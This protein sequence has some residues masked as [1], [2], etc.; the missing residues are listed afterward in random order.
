MRSIEEKRCWAVF[1]LSTSVGSFF[2][3]ENS[4]GLGREKISACGLEASK[5]PPMM[6]LVLVLKGVLSEVPAVCTTL[7]VVAGFK[8]L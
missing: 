7:A 3:A 2:C 4:S 8:N 5:P 6:L 1:R